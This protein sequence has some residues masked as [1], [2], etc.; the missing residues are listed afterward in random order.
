VSEDIAV[1]LPG[2]STFHV[3]GVLHGHVPKLESP[4]NCRFD[5]AHYREILALAAPVFDARTFQGS[6]RQGRGSRPLLLLR[7]DVDHSLEDALVLARIENEIGIPATYFVQI[8]CPFYSVMDARGRSCL[9]ELQQLGHEIGFHYDVSYYRAANE[10]IPQAFR[11]DLH[12]LEQLTGSPIRSIARHDP[13]SGAIDEETLC[14]IRATVECD[15]YAD[16]FFRRIRYVSDST[17]S[18]RTG[19]CCS[20]LVEPADIQ[21]LVHPVWWVNDGRDWKEKLRQSNRRSSERLAALTEDV[22]GYYQQIL[23]DRA[24]RDTLF[25]A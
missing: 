24:T 21:V 14:A 23:D 15:A 5:L 19:C 12:V 16:D 11:R 10:A 22:I 8:H 2:A 13:A 25:S 17:C 9:R 18:W 6:R 7:H 1:P 4:M 20:H 3:T